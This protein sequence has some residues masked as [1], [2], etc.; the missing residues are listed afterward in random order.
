MKNRS[1]QLFRQVKSESVRQVTIHWDKDKQQG[2]EG[3]SV[4]PAG[5][6]KNFAQRNTVFDSFTVLRSYSPEQEV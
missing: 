1:K 5:Q 2:V 6:L 4:Q 3:Q